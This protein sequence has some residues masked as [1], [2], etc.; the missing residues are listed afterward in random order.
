M[1]ELL[2]EIRN[3]VRALIVDR[4]SILLLRKEGGGGGERF[5]LPGGGQ[6][7]GETLKEAL[8][9]ECIEEIGTSVEVGNLIHVTDFFK[10]RDTQPPTQRHLVEFLFACVIPDHYSPHNGHHPDK[11]QVEV[12]WAEINDIPQLPIYPQ[13][14]S[15]C[16]SQYHEIDK[17]LYLGSF[18]DHATS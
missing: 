9:R 14:L 3:A 8:N 11:H 7:T 1:A 18:H 12:I 4:G 17:H 6:D 16:I 10:L 13:F 5:A 2:P 15:T